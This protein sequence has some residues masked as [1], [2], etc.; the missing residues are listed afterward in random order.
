[1]KI[2]LFSDLHLAGE[3]IPADRIFREIPQCD[4]AIC[5][6]DLI[7]GD[8][9]AGVEWLA[10]HIRSHVPALAY[11]LGNHEFWDTAGRT[12]SME[13]LRAE[14][15]R[16]GA[17]HGIDVL[18][19]MALTLDDVRILGTTL[20]SS[21]PGMGHQE[22][23]WI[24]PRDASSAMLTPADVQAMHEESVRWL[25]EELSASDRPTVVVTHHAPHPDCIGPV[26]ADR[27][28]GFATDMSDLIIRHQ[29][30][31]WLHGHTHYQ[32]DFMIG[33]TR[34]TSNQKGH[35]YDMGTDWDPGR[36]IEI[37]TYSPRLKI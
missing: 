6:G 33:G 26:N 17:R 4:V 35:P 1:M 9:A 16:A 7:T 3:H 27:S 20:W 13:R 24:R 32:S 8:P 23:A 25:D 28:P 29:P 36:V 2:W 18:D 22:Y 37:E 12:K 10:E 15:G 14:A 21:E 30:V 5:A 31:A 11:V 19:D 34:V